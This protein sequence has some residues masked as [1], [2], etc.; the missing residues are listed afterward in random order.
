M[1]PREWIA[2]AGLPD[3][4]LECVLPVWDFSPAAPALPEFL[5]VDFF[6]RWY[7]LTGCPEELLPEVERVCRIAAENPV[8]RIYANLVFRVQLLEPPRCRFSRI[9]SLEK[10]LGPRGVGVL[11]LMMALGSL[12][13]VAAKH[14]ELGLPAEHLEGVARW[15][16]GT[17]GIY[18][19]GHEG[20]PGHDLGQ[21]FWLRY[22]MEGRLFRV[23]RF[24][25]FIQRAPEWLPAI[26]RHCRSGRTIALA[27]DG[28]FA[29]PDG[30]RCS[31][32]EAGATALRFSETPDTVRG[33]PIDPASGRCEIEQPVILSRSEFL[34]VIAAH[35]WVPGV[36]IPGGG[37]MTPERAADSLRRAKVF[38]QRYFNREVPAFV[39]DSWIL[40][41]DWQ[42]ELP[43]S[44][45]TKF[46]RELYLCS[47]P[48]DPEAGLFFVFGRSGGDRRCYPADTSIRRAF[49]RIWESGRELRPGG[50]FLLTA[51][52]DRFGTAVYR[53]TGGRRALE[54]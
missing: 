20:I 49:H 5:T 2:A 26:Y 43:E 19:A 13:Y 32:E 40:N 52:L 31:P 44:N 4:F 11:Q 42:T 21:L 37:G 30:M 22:S 14:A 51:D 7:P 47:F 34:P 3:D 27:P 38:F 24:E 23:G 15:I 18:K 8:V 25:Y 48:V 10:L 9:P 17:V 1:T 28:W 33:I 45:L 46:M 36:H 35:D 12:P 53:T 39:C 50:M 29:G 16:G 54:A 6:R 41:P